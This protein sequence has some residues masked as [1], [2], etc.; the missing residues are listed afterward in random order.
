ME[1][2]IGPDLGVG[3]QDPSDQVRSGRLPVAEVRGG[4]QT[5]EVELVGVEHQADQG[6]AVVRLG[7]PGG[8]AAD[9]RQDGQAG[10]FREGRWWDRSIKAEQRHDQDGPHDALLRQQRP[11]LA[12][13]SPNPRSVPG[14]HHTWRAAGGGDGARRK[15]S[16]PT[17]PRHGAPQ[18]LP[19]DRGLVAR[20]GRVDLQL[21]VPDKNSGKIALNK[22]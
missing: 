3:V 8:Q 18:D 21:A 12:S 19:L 15:S 6:L 4:D 13:R 16:S 22:L 2:E 14:R 9:V 1:G 7:D 11:S 10:P 17:S 5:L 20:S